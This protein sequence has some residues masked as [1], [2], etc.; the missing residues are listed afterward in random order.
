MGRIHHSK[1]AC[2]VVVSGDEAR[3][4]HDLYRVHGG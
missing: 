1:A 3:V 4:T 2:A